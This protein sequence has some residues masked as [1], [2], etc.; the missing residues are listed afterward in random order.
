MDRLRSRA[1]ILVLLA[2]VPS[3]CGA[4]EDRPGGNALAAIETLTAIP[5]AI[6]TATALATLVPVEEMET[7]EPKDTGTVQ[8]ASVASMNTAQATTDDVTGAV[9]RIE[10]VGTFEALWEGLPYVSTGSGSGFLI[11]EDGQILTNAHVVLGAA[12]L[13]VYVPGNVNPLSGR[14]LASDECSDLALVKVEGSDFPVLQLATGDPTLDVPVRALGYPSGATDPGETSGT[15]LDLEARGASSWAA[16]PYSVQHS[17]ELHSGNSGGPLLDGNNAVVGINYAGDSAGAAWAVPIALVNSVL[18]QMR[19]GRAVAF[20]T[21]INGQAFGSRVSEM[22]GVFV[23]SVA[24][25]SPAAAAGIRAG[26][27]LMQLEQLPLAQDGTLR[28]YCDILRSR[29]QTDLLEV[30]V[31]RRS[32]HVILVGELNGAR[33]E[34]VEGQLPEPEPPT[35]APAYLPATEIP[36]LVSAGLPDLDEVASKLHQDVMQQVAAIDDLQD[37]RIS[38]S[39]KWCADSVERLAQNLDHFTVVFVVDGVSYTEDAVHRTNTEELIDVAGK[40]GVS[41][42][43]S[44]SRIALEQWGSGVHR[45]VVSAYLDAEISDGWSTFP[46]DFVDEKFY[47]VRVN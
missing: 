34:E 24:T 21:G 45:A 40:T 25:G 37:Q 41:S 15:V 27:L 22:R 17:A 8:P 3:A 31:Y 47:E 13:R 6:S 42:Q 7:I 14:V 5:T 2:I 33:L 23:S 30:R 11:S 43:C 19:A 35:A 26:D 18:S 32:D 39:W 1:L 12:L 20:A 38:L 4:L 46:K 10:T 16:L 28:D 29:V 9:V 36:E 44:T